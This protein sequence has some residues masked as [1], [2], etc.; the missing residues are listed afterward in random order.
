M[1]EKRISSLMPQF[2]NSSC[3][4]VTRASTGSFA[5]R[6]RVDGRVKPGHD[7][8]YATEALR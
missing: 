8:Q 6:R 4:G 1:G 5:Q 2:V 3:A 7:S